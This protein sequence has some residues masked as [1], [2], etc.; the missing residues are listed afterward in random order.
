MSP[1]RGGETGRVPGSAFWGGFVLSWLAVS[2]LG[3]FLLFLFLYR[4]FSSPV[5]GGYGEVFYALHH[6]STTLLPVIALSVL[7]YVF[8]AGAA[9]AWLCIAFLHRVAG[10][11]FKLEKSLGAYLDGDPVRPMFFRH[12]DLVPELAS[13]FNRFVGRLRE[14]RQRW[15]GVME[16]AERLCLQDRK[17][18][19]AEMEKSLAELDV[20]LFRYR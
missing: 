15:L 6:M 16:N 10:P 18:C 17:T 5:S 1:W 9:A 7:V 20:L 2:G 13:A 19:R 14:D 8:I 4:F 12:S 11:V 3:T